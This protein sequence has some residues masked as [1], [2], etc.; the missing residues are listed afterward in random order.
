MNLFSELNCWRAKDQGEKYHIEHL[1]LLRIESF[2][3]V[4]IHILLGMCL[5]SVN[6]I[7]SSF[8]Y[9][10]TSLCLPQAGETLDFIGTVCPSVRPSVV[11]LSNNLCPWLSKNTH[12]NF[13]IL[14]RHTPWEDLMNW[15]DFG[16]DD[17]IFNSASGRKVT[18]PKP[19]LCTWSFQCL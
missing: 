12:P 15:L 2:K 9:L 4:W 5:W 6:S 11:H 10:S 17:L 16:S 7:H 18:I 1:I 13:V 19:F 14:G 8:N 3:W